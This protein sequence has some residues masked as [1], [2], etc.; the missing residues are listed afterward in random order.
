MPRSNPASTT[1]TPESPA[2]EPR[3]PDV[4][5]TDSSET[6]EPTVGLGNRKKWEESD[7]LDEKDWLDAPPERTYADAMTAE[8]RE[9]LRGMGKRV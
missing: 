2:V 7:P 4:A 9:F 3:D 1:G 6:A 8:H 5:G